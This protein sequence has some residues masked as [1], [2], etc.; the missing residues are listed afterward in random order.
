MTTCEPTT[1]AFT[2]RGPI[3]RGDLPGLYARVCSLFERMRPQVAFCVLDGVRA[4][5]VVADALARLQLGARRRGCQVRLRN[6]PADVLQ[7]LAF[8]GLSEV[9]PQ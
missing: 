6:A 7:L 8:M 1:I 3:E 9:L 2:I 5:A 4:D